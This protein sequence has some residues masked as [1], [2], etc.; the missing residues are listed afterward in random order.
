MIVSSCAS[1]IVITAYHS[2]APNF[3]IST[4]TKEL[5]PVEGLR[6][7]IAS[8]LIDALDD[9]LRFALVEEMP[10]CVGLVGKVNKSP[11]T[12]DAHEHR[13]C[14]FDDE[15]PS[16]KIPGQYVPHKQSRRGSSYLQPLSP[17][18]PLSCISPYLDG[19]SMRLSHFSHWCILL[20]PRYQH[21][22]RPDFRGCRRPSTA[23]QCHSEYTT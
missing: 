10:G 18:R 8:I 1:T 23:F 7:R 15:D 12:N 16:A 13:Q 2:E 5:L 9:E 19:V 3:D 21:M 22:L 14:S 4:T 11:V 20:T 6:P 17:S